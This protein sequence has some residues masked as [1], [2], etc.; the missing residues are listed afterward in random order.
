MNGQIVRATV[1][2][3]AIMGIAAGKVQATTIYSDDFSGGSGTNLNGTAP[4][5]RPGLETWLASGWTAN[6]AISSGGTAANAWL[7]F[8]P[9]ANTLYQLSL[10]LNPTA[11]TAGNW[12]ALGFS[13]SSTTTSAFGA[14]ANA[15]PWLY[16]RG[17]NGNYQ[18]ESALGPGNNSF[19]SFGTGFSGATQILI[20]LDTRNPAWT[21]EWFVDGVSQRGPV[22]YAT[23][24]TINFVG[25]GRDGDAVGSVSNFQ[26]VAVP[27]PAT[28][29][30]SA[31]AGLAASMIRLRRRRAG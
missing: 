3:I 7:P 29:C 10:S 5:V 20:E 14:G 31:S 22:A 21:A 18:V 25:F 26:L 17:P 2:C 30:L 4:D 9:Q 24:P 28:W 11:N 15:A 27:E 6:G 23:N 13:P 16:K 1:V 8:T 19:V 12:F